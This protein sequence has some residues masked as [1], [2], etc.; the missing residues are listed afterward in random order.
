M[1]DS[2]ESPS[3]EPVP[4]SPEPAASPAPSPTLT[5]Q[6]TKDGRILPPRSEAAQRKLVCGLL[7][8]LLAGLGIHKFILGYTGPGVIMLGISMVSAFMVVL[9]SWILIGLC[10]LPVLGVVSVISII[11]GIIYLTKTDDQFYETYMVNR[12]DWF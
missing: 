3:R 6:Y 2:G 11:E 12:R 7:A 4:H 1:N 8:I 10:C 5:L 9:L